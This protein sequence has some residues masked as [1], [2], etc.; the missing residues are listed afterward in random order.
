M[1]FWNKIGGLD[2]FGIGIMRHEKYGILWIK[3]WSEWKENMTKYE[4]FPVKMSFWNFPI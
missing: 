3:K 2:A 4:Y 1:G